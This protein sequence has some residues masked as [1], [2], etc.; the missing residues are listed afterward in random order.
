MS[1]WKMNYE[2]FKGHHYHQ[3]MCIEG[4]CR[5]D[6]IKRL[7]AVRDAAEIIVDK[8]EYIGGIDT[9]LWNALVDALYAVARGKG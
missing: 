6:Y 7:E 4:N 9:D 5:E 2:G 8:S 1:D 3:T